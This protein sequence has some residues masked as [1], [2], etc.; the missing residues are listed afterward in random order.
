[1][2]MKKKLISIII[3]IAAILAIAIYYFT[4]TPED[5]N[6]RF[7]EAIASAQVAMLNKQYDKAISMYT[8]ALN[9][10]KSDIAFSGMFNAYAALNDWKNAEESLNSAISLNPLNPEMWKNKLTLMNEKTNATYDDLQKTY[11]QGMKIIPI[12]SRIDLVTHFARISENK[13]RISDSI[14][15]WRLAIQ[16]YP[17][18]KKAYQSEID[19]LSKL[20]N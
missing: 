16:L 17:D 6:K 4:R 3:L 11:D 10:K 13:D 12:D 15:L 1:M 7:D 5:I 2:Y 14:K 8:I 9:N 18:N 20:L 19:M